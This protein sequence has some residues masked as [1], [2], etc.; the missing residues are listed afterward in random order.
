M[1]VLGRVDFRGSF[2][3]FYFELLLAP[4]CH[5]DWLCRFSYLLLALRF[6]LLLDEVP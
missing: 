4:L 2:E 6:F 3:F 5:F 1:R